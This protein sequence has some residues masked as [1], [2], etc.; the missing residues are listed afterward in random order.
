MVG[1]WLS[2][3]APSVVLKYRPVC[4]K[5]MGKIRVLD[6]LHS[7]MNYS[8]TGWEFNAIESTIYIK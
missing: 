3:V 5:P 8:A 1:V 7:G 4:P 2:K 6:E